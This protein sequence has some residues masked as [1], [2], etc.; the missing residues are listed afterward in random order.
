MNHTTDPLTEANDRV[1][2]YVDRTG[3]AD[4]RVAYEAVFKADP[5]LA[6][7]HKVANQK[8]IDAGGRIIHYGAG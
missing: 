3:E 7:R 2:I 1:R 8:V 5:E 6:A 4:L